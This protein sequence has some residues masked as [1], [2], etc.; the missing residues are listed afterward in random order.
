MVYAS[1]CATVLFTRK[2]KIQDFLLQP[3]GAH[4]PFKTDFK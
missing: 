4:I 1:K 2:N 3:H